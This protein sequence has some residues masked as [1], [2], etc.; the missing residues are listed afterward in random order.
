MLRRL[1]LCPP[2]RGEGKQWEVVSKKNKRR[3]SGKLGR[4]LRPALRCGSSDASYVC[5]AAHRV[6]FTP[7]SA[8]LRADV[9]EG[10]LEGLYRI[11]H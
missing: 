1:L 11:A 9:K 10:L 2:V 3:R 6:M 5:N 7:R 8:M 4:V